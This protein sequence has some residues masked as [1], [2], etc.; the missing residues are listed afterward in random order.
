[1]IVVEN[2][3]RQNRVVFDRAHLASFLNLHHGSPTTR[4]LSQGKWVDATPPATARDFFG[5][6]N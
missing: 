3:Q 4:P 2:T 6:A 5:P 1:M